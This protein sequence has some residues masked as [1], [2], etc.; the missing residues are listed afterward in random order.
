MS[1]IRLSLLEDGLYA[2]DRNGAITEDAQRPF[3][4]ARGEGRRGLGR[5]PPIPRG[6][7]PGER[8]PLRRYLARSM[9]IEAAALPDAEAEGPL[10]ILVHG[11]QFDPSK[12]YFAPPH[13]KKAGNPHARLYHFERHAPEVEM[14]HH[15]TGWPLGLGM[16]ADDGGAAGLAVGF[17]WDSDPGILES[18][19]RDGL[20][21]YVVAYDFAEEH[22]AWQL[23]CLVEA[24]ERILRGR[25]SR[26]R[27]DLFC[28]SLGSR[29]VVRALAQAAAE[30]L[31]GS[32]FEGA[33]RAIDAVDRV[34]ILAGAERVLEAQLMMRRLNRGVSGTDRGAAVFPRI[35]AFYNIVS[36]END[37]LD[38]L[39]ENFGPRARGS[40]QVIGHNGLEALD[41]AWIDIQLDDPDVAHWFRGRDY[42]VSGDNESSVFAVLDHWIHYTWPDN[43]RVYHDILRDRG[44]WEIGALKAEAPQLFDRR[45]LIRTR[46]N[47]PLTDY[48]VPGL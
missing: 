18:F 45:R 9:E 40:K 36:R 21:P 19:F 47:V 27:I 1:I 15:S 48:D 24:L 13:H 37:V 7:F 32:A 25:G 26:R 46:G 6:S 12:A 5:M 41:P 28:H 35:P 17:G 10:V 11:F 30:D 2:P 20:N 34:V 29:V 31:R 44:A 43:M 22:A 33:A 23:V 42:R 14:R 16:R 4:Q 39:G 38:I 8:H 3:S